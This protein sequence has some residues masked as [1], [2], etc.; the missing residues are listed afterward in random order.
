MKVIA[1]YNVKGGVGKTT[2]AVNLAYLSAKSGKKT[3]IWDADLQG[4][5]SLLLQSNN[6]KEKSI[7]VIS[8]SPKNT[9]SYT[10]STSYKNLDIL[11]ADFSSSMNCS[12]RFRVSIASGSFSRAGY[13]LAGSHFPS[14]SRP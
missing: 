9:R 7:N 3:L 5:A 13:F 1:C 2:T 12:R 11:P 6:G 14:G 10:H 8:D 4:S